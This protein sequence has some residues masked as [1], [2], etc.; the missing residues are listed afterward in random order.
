MFFSQPLLPE[1]EGMGMDANEGDDDMPF[2]ELEFY[3]AMPQEQNLDLDVLLWWKARDHNHKPD[4]SSGRPQGLPIPTLAR[5]VR[6]HFGR[7]ASSAGVER[8]F[9]KAGKLHDDGKASQAD[10]TL[11][12][13]LLAAANCDL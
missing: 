11:Q 9:S 8:M 6:Q 10:D 4:A 7:P 13:Y 2:D 5:M 3:L 12:H 1:M